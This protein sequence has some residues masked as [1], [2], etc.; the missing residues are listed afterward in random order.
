MKAGSIRFISVAVIIAVAGGCSPK[1]TPWPSMA[2]DIPGIGEDS[3]D[4]YVWDRIRTWIDTSGVSRRQSVDMLPQGAQ[5]FY[6]TWTLQAEVG[7]GGL[8][9]AFWNGG[10]QLAETSIQGL[11]EVGADGAARAARDGFT[12]YQASA[13]IGGYRAERDVAESDSVL[14]R[15]YNEAQRSLDLSAQDGAFYASEGSLSVHRRA[16]VRAN[17][18]QF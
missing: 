7:N 2:Q 14:I 16:Y 5:T 12:A 4:V 9:Q 10:N 6:L 3:L 18:H 15:I 1:V 8:F 13:E 11:E 17:A